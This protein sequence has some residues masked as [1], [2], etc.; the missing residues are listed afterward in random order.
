MRKIFLGIFVVSFL[1]MPVILTLVA[2]EES[3]V[4]LGSSKFYAPISRGFGTVRPKE[5]F[6]GGDPS[7]HVTNITWDSWGGAE[8]TGHG[9]NA[10]FKPAGGY[11]ATQVRID[12]SARNVGTCPGESHPSYRQLFAREPSRPGGKPGKWFLW[13]EA[14]DLCADG[15]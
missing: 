4:T 12:L 5:I 15:P 1:L 14:H 13:A 11:Y 2:A 10:I 9:M 7:G 3:Q 8:A 6:N